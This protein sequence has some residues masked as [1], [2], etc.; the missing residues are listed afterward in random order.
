[1]HVTNGQLFSSIMPPARPNGYFYF[2][3]NSISKL[4]RGKFASAY[5]MLFADLH[6]YALHIACVYLY[7]NIVRT[8]RLHAQVYRL[9]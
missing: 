9:I 2:R 1:M 3:R 6:H 7:N 8:T 5:S 4:L